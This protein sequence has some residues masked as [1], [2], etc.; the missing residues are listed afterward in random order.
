MK[1]SAKNIQM[2]AFDDLF[3]GG[4]P[5]EAEGDGNVREIPLAIPADIGWK[6]QDGYMTVNVPA[7]MLDDYVESFRQEILGQE[8]KTPE[9]SG[10]GRAAGE[11]PKTVEKVSLLARLKENAPKPGQAAERAQEKD[12]GRQ[13]GDAR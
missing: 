8:K 3:P 2:T 9:R 10:P 12:R 4:S 5:P 11:K 1:S 7:F 13:R 6:M